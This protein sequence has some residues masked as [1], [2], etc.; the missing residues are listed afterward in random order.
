MSEQLWI[1]LGILFFVSQLIGHMVTQTDHMQGAS[2]MKRTRGAI[3]VVVLGALWPL[4]AVGLLGF[5]G[6]WIGRHIGR[7]IA[8]EARNG[9]AV[10]RRGQG[11]A[12]A[13][14]RTEETAGPFRSLPARCHSCGS[15]TDS[16]K[17]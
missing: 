6:Q 5:G 11:A 10:L 14:A 15:F 13:L 9:L 7:Y 16:A 4:I 8:W 12:A 2:G 3:I 1:A 17:P